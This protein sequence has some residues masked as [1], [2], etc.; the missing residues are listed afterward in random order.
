M[1]D[2]IGASLEECR[3]VEGGIDVLE[4]VSVSSNELHS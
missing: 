2:K 3:A 1:D 4:H